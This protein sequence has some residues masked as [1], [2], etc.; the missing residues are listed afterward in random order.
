MQSLNHRLNTI[1]RLNEAKGLFA[2]NFVTISPYDIR[3]RQFQRQ[4][5]LIRKKFVGIFC[6]SF[7]PKIKKSAHTHTRK[8]QQ[9]SKIAN[10]N[11]KYGQTGKDDCNGRTWNILFMGSH[12]KRQQFTHIGI[13]NVVG[14]RV[15]KKGKY[16]V[17]L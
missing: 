14:T 15:E 2:R 17:T 3:I 16:C 4:H 11:P 1:D 13:S 6:F 9:V 5:S 7:G 12:G 10:D 8:I